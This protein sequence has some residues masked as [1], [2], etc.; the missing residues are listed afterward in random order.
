M[1]ANEI[2]QG[3]KWHRHAPAFAS[4]LAFQLGINIMNALSGFILVRSLSKLEYGWL[5]IAISLGATLAVMLDPFTGSTLQAEAAKSDRT[6]RQLGTLVNTVSKLLLSRGIWI[7]AA[8]LFWFVTLLL[9]NGLPLPEAFT[10]CLVIITGYIPLSRAIT[11]GQILRFKSCH[12]ISQT[13]DLTNAVVRLFCIATLGVASWLTA[14][15]GVLSVAAGQT[16]QLFVIRL[17][18]ASHINESAAASPEVAQAILQRARPLWIHCLFFCFQGQI[19]LWI[20]GVFGST[21]DLAD[22][23]ALG[24]LSILLAPVGN[25][26]QQFAIPRLARL[27]TS[28]QLRKFALQSLL[29]FAAITGLLLIASVEVP[30][31]FLWFLGGQYAS[32]Q[33]EVPLLIGLC[34]LTTMSLFV[35]GANICRGWTSL[36]FW[37]PLACLTS[38]TAAGCILKPVVTHSILLFLIAGQLPSL[39]LAL[40][41]QV[42]GMMMNQ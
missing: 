14:L 40:I 2:T 12:V 19:G 8:A 28:I 37:V 35:W 34:C 18:S 26:G 23:G 3:K 27:Q 31:A 42:R 38:Y 13:S 32:L 20:M 41:Q 21:S 15:A 29:V 17:Q 6:P 4:F 30:G 11:M 36:A 25:F 10:L 1:D 22:L 5:T 16:A 39:I 33:N 7:M 24:R 9:K